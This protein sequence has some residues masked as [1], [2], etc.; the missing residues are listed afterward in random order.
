MLGQRDP[1]IIVRHQSVPIRVS[2]NLSDY[3]GCSAETGASPSFELIWE[4]LPITPTT[5]YECVAQ[6]WDPARLLVRDHLD[7]ALKP[8]IMRVLAENFGV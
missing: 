2:R 6:R 8:E 4:F 3:A 7:R 1:L 5:Y